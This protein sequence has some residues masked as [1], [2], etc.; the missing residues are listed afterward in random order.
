MRPAP[1]VRFAVG[2]VLALST[3]VAAKAQA[4]PPAAPP[5]PPEPPAGFGTNQANFCNGTY[6]L[7]IKAPCTAIPTLDRLGN[8]YIDHALC[9]CD[10]VTGWSMGPGACEDRAPTTQH[11]R[12]FLISTYSNLYNDSAQ[13]LQCD[14]HTL[15]AWCYSAPCVVD[16]AHPGKAV[17]TC[18]VETGNAN[19][20]GA[21][22]P[23]M[24]GQVWSAA[25]PAGDCF[26]NARYYEWAIQNGQQSNPP[27][28]LC[29]SDQS[30]CTPPPT[31]GKA[32]PSSGR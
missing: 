8:Y 13:V 10:V 26:A 20:L 18:P 24:C 32:A 11:G 28:L 19:L 6:A 7:C 3:A 9:S 1:A 29:E 27:A 2:L 5:P 4:T 12:T 23:A 21:C 16:Q 30:V 31:V 25:T 22:D 15:W 14:Q 17:C